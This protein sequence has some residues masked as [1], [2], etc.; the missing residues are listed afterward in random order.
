MKETEIKVI[1]LT[2]DNIESMIYVIRGQRVMLDFDL[3]RIYGYETKRFNEQVKNNA[4]K[5]PIE[6]MFKLSKE[7][8]G[9]ILMSKKSASSWG[10]TRKLPYAFTEQG[11]YMLMTVLKGELATKQSIALIKAF[12]EMKD[13]IVSSNGIV[14]SKEILSLSMQVNNNT[15]S[16]KELEKDT[17][18]I[19]NQLEVVM[20]NFIDPS[21]YKQFLFLNGEKLEADIAYQQIYASAKRSIYIVDDYIDVKTFYLLRTA[22]NN[23]DITI[24][25][26][27]ASKN[28]L[29]KEFI[30]DFTNQCSNHIHMIRTNNK[31]HDRFIIVDYKQESEKVYIC[32]SSSKDAGNRITTITRVDSGYLY[33]PLVESMLKNNP[34]EIL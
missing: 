33:H 20:D 7:E 32:G 10:G 19:K 4:N 15:Q 8:N 12:K 22:N 13:Y 2:L 11:I 26:D 18:S 21:T 28:S 3:A 27:N 30:D 1:E 34:L 16:I 14:N 25:T 5:F 23:V 6:F 29:T 9:K 31:C 24:F 17:A